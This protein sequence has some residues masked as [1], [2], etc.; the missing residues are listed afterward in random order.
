MHGAD[1]VPGFGFDGDSVEGCT[2]STVSEAAMSDEP[3]HAIPRLP[4]RTTRN[5]RGM[6]IG[7]L[8]L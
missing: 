2:K 4:E 1:D 7:G 3:P 5:T 6:M 8:F